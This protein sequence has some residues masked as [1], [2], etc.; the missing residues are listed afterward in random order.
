MS[1]GASSVVYE[2]KV[3]VTGGRWVDNEDN[4]TM[5]ALTLDDKAEWISVPSRLPC[6]ISS[7]KCLVYKDR[8]FLMGGSDNAERTI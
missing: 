5:E 8:L 2:S 7:H 3:I 6:K 1:S 4:D